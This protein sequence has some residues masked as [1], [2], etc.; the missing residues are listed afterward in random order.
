[1]ASV[2]LTNS[3]SNRIR[4]LVS[5]FLTRGRKSPVMKPHYLLMFDTIVKMLDD[6]T[7]FEKQEINVVIFILDSYFSVF[8]EGD[9]DPLAEQAY[10]KLTGH[11]PE[12]FAEPYYDRVVEYAHL[13]DY[14][15]RPPSREKLGF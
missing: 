5:T 10:C 9:I 13:V 4:L 12:V 11:W 8:K 2:V 15:V 3:Q 6:N 1:M 7:P 14:K